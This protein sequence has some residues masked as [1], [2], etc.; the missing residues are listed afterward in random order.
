MI[1]RVL[2]QAYKL[3]YL[4]E[5]RLQLIH[6]P[7]HAEEHAWLFRARKHLLKLA[8][9]TLLGK[10]PYIHR[11]AELNGIRVHRKVQSRGKTR[12]PKDS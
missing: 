2:L 1:H 7:Q 8:F 12:A 3:L 11:C 5:P 10:R 4:R 6:L 9:H